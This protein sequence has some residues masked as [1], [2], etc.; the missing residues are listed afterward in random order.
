MCDVLS[1]NIDYEFS[2]IECSIDSLHAKA[3]HAAAANKGSC[4]DNRVCDQRK[5]L[6]KKEKRKR[7]LRTTTMMTEMVTLH[8]G[9][10]EESKRS[11]LRSELRLSTLLTSVG[12]L[13]L[14]FVLLH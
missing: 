13:L 8:C 2:A 9:M 3:D 5:L 11:S 10:I 1:L 7:R 4:I 12:V 14:V 6:S